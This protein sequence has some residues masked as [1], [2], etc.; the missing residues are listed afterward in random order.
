VCEP[1]SFC[2]EVTLTWNLKE[3][4][5]KEELGWG[6]RTCRKGSNAY[7]DSDQE[8]R[9][10]RKQDM[11]VNGFSVVKGRVAFSSLTKL[12]SVSLAMKYARPGA[13]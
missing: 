12:G 3:K 2:G 1:Q 7:G 4:F 5:P 9:V 10:W 11:V 8:R 13:C 6:G